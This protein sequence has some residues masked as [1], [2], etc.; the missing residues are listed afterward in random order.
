MREQAK[1]DHQSI[2]TRAL[3]LR[4]ATASTS[5]ATDL[6]ALGVAELSLNQRV[7]FGRW[8][9]RQAKMPLIQ[10]LRGIMA[11]NTTGSR[12]MF[13]VVGRRILGGD[14]KFQALRW[15]RQYCLCASNFNFFDARNIA[16]P[17][18]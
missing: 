12:A 1:P 16:R 17:R 14:S 13:L 18:V 11:E 15:S 10:C 9:A 5:R 3:H 2:S 8:C 6:E 4:I 7:R